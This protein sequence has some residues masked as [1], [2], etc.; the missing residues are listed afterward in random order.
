MSYE[1]RVKR[2]Q[3]PEIIGGMFIL[4]GSILLLAVCMFIS[5]SSGPI[6]LGTEKNTNGLVQYLCLGSGC[7]DLP[8]VDW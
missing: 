3:T 2:A 1:L 5:L 7:E 6:I 8:S 4:F